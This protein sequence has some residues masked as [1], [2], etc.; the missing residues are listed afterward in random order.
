M[1]DRAADELGRRLDGWD[2][3]PATSEDPMAPAPAAALAAAL[4]RPPPATWLPPLWHWLHFLHWPPTEA[5]GPDGHPAGG[6]FLP[7]LPER[8][9]M[10]VGGRHEIEQGGKV[11]VVDEQ[12]LM[13]RSGPVASRPASVAAPAVTPVSDAVWQRPFTA[14]A[15][16]LFRFSALTANTHRIH[17]DRPYAT[18]VEGYPGLVV[19]GPLLA[20]ALAGL[21]A[22]H[23][24]DATV[25]SMRYRFVL[26]VFAGD[27]TLLT[28]R[29]GPAGAELAVVGANGS[30]CAQADVTYS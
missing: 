25:A 1:A 7:P 6:D 8:T 22:D 10:F 29:P 15:V 13:Y 17:Y 30:P 19:H 18:D 9:R 5:L 3:P 21:A 27:P 23:A 26:P 16:L 4:D 28:G 14:G 11:A 2:P 20:V 12:D 24:P